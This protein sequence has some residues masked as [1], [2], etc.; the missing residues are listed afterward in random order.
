MDS[1]QFQSWLSSAS[2]PAAKPSLMGDIGA[3]WN[4]GVGKIGQGINEAK[5]AGG[6]GVGGLVTGVGKIVGGA[7]QAITSP[8]APALNATLGKGVNAVGNFI[9]DPT[10]GGA[11]NNPSAQAHAQAMQ[12]FSNT[13][14]GKTTADVASTVGDYANA[15][16]TI[17][18]GAGVPDAIASAGSKVAG[19]LKGAD[20]VP[21]APELAAS[22][23]AAATKVANDAQTAKLA[24]AWNP[25][26]TA[27]NPGTFKVPNKIL[28]ANPGLDKFIAEQKV[29]P[30]ENIQNGH[31]QTLDTVDALRA[32]PGKLDAQ[33]LTPA[34]KLEDTHNPISIKTSDIGSKALSN[35][36]KDPVANTTPHNAETLQ[37][38]T[39]AAIDALNRKYPTGMSREQMQTEK[40]Q[41]GQQ[42]GFKP[43]GVTDENNT[44]TVNRNIASALQKIIEANPP[45]GVD[46]GAFNKYLSQYYKAAD[47]MKSLDAKPV[48]KTVTQYLLNRGAQGVGAVL[49]HAIPGGGILTGILGYS[50]AGTMEHAFEN[51]TLPMRYAYLKGQEAVHPEAVTKIQQYLQDQ[52]GGSPTTPRLNPAGGNPIPQGPASVP[53]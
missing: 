10:M 30:A 25:G 48:P 9:A 38:N 21:V 31:Y 17:A 13:P 36:A 5:P 41:Y 14:A 46:V 11:N 50:V 20:Q 34:L 8:I 26:K 16:G 29:N 52:M 4:A 7:A 27:K 45:K 47:Y 6:G 49:G 12:G 3:A 32:E 1:S 33:G 43:G 53:K 44:A 2:T 51:M 39:Q 15:A 18:A 37:T 42:S 24:E 40:I 28:R 22:R 35:L 19:A 23:A